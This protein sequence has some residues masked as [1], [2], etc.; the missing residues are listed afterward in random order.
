VAQRIH[1]NYVENISLA[2]IGVV[3]AGLVK[4]NYGVAVGI[5]YMIG[6]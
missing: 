2:T 3:A 5:A 1:L 4:P 6:R